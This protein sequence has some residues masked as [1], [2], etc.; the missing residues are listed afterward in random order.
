MTFKGTLYNLILI[1][2][3]RNSNNEYS[4][5]SKLH[6]KDQINRFVEE[7][8]TQ[9]ILHANNHVKYYRKVFDQ[10]DLIKNETVD[11]SRISEIPILTKEIIR[12][13][14]QDLISDD[15][16]TRKWFNTAS[17]GSTGEPVRLIQD[18]IYSK[19]AT[20]TNYYYYKNILGI[21]EPIVKKVILW[22]SE[23][24]LL[25]GSEGLKEKVYTWLTN[26]V[27]L[28][29]FRMTES[30]I[31]QY[32]NTIN[33]FKPVIV[34]GYA[35]SLYELCRYA[36]RNK[37][38][39]YTPTV[40]VSTAELLTDGMRE[41]IQSTFGTKVYNFYGSREVGN[42][43]GECKEGLMHPFMFWNYQELLDS[44]NQPVKEGEEGR[45]I[46]TNLF[47]YS[48]PLIRYDIGDTAILGQEN[49][50][51]GLMLPTFKEIMGRIT[52]QFLLEN[53]TTVPSLYFL[54]LLSVYSNKDK[55]EKFQIIQEDYNKIRIL[56]VPKGEV[57]DSYKREVM[58]KI[59]VVMG[60]DC[61]VEWDIVD[62]I[63]KT[64]SG[65]YLYAKSLI[66]R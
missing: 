35:G 37:L 31:E 65:K 15:Y 49:C 12:K 60:R 61:K 46:A 57:T 34:R 51:C 64:P 18:D 24:D 43:A 27:F 20:A 13:H 41:T 39:L 14:H 58:E 50:S 53:G 23:R 11:L 6:N 26:T 25:E 32:I 42:L 5:I 48:M 66:G 8:L 44:H 28:N 16:Q 54:W 10:I 56:V 2:L 52:D 38:A 33:N 21:E 55:I 19:W 47:N 22:G 7:K 3:K 30:D 59:R 4:Q 1:T 9:L 62:D 40:V 36:E 29:S 17:G 63:P 45:V